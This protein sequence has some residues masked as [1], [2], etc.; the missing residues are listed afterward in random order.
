MGKSHQLMREEQALMSNNPYKNSDNQ[1]SVPHDKGIRVDKMVLI[2]RPPQDV[3]RFW[4]NL[5]NL[6]RFMDNLKSVKMIDDKRSHWVA[7][8]PANINVE[9]DA[10][11]INDVPNEVIG[12]RSLDGAAVANAGSVQFKPMKDGQATEVKVE[13]KYDPPAGALG[14]AVAKLFGEHPDKQVEEDLMRLKHLLDSAQ[15]A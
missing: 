9:W 12:W 1:V 11:I 13:M 3:Y 15:T 10:E 6:P 8:G 14:D 4:R 2:H 5:E 7:K